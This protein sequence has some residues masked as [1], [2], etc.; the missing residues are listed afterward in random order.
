MLYEELATTRFDTM[1]QRPA[2]LPDYSAPPVT[3][4]IVGVQFNAIPNFHSVHL[5]IIWNAFR[6]DFPIVQDHFPLPSTFE[7]FGQNPAIAFP[8]FNLSLPGVEIPRVFF[9]DEPQTKLLQVQKDR[10]IHNWRKLASTDTYPRFEEML[11]TFQQNYRRFCEALKSVGL[12]DPQPNQCELVYVNHIDVDEDGGF[13]D[14]F[15]TIFPGVASS[16]APDALG[17]PEDVR[18]LVR[19]PIRMDD[20]APYGRV[21]ISIEPATKSDGKMINQ[22][23]FTSRGRP[24]T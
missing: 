16:F 24:L 12:S 2:G 23:S 14:G 13:Y 8:V 9:V 15:R 20:G 4:V 10:F 18:L 21:L 6:K 22:M 19:Y 5:G 17:D 3:E 7:T 1:R 11:D